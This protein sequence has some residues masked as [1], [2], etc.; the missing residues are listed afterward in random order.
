M[1]CLVPVDLL[2]TLTEDRCDMIASLRATGA[3]RAEGRG[4]PAEMFERA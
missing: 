2:L 4:R 1:G 3:V